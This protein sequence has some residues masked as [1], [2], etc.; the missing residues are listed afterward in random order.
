MIQ[1]VTDVVVIFNETKREIAKEVKISEKDSRVI[2]KLISQKQDIDEE[3][4]ELKK[5]FDEL[6]A[7]AQEKALLVEEYQ[8]LEIMGNGL[9]DDFTEL[10]WEAN[11]LFAQAAILKN[12]LK[13]SLK[14]QS[15]IAKIFKMI[16]W[17]IKYHNFY[18]IFM[19]KMACV[20]KKCV[21]EK[22]EKVGILNFPPNFFALFM[23]LKEIF[24]I[25]YL[26][27]F[28]FWNYFFYDKFII[29]KCS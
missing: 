22:R 11:D 18:G 2:E 8:L 21:K 29:F 5:N 3:V 10:V 25:I 28:T 9:P 12:E 16:F 17:N 23:H 4:L 1:K 27:F 15:V 24:F 13:K 14:K 20:G 19:F 6:L 7:E 26:L